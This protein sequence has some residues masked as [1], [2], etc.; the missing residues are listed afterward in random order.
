MW[1]VKKN[2]GEERKKII[3]LSCAQ[4][5]TRQTI[6]FA[7]CKKNTRQCICR[8]LTHGKA[9]ILLCVFFAMRFHRGTRQNS[10]LPCARQKAHGKDLDT[11]HSSD[12]W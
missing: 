2:R 11:R 10:S 9:W 8:V 12:F 3:T 4:N 5:N 6:D 7:V 1:R